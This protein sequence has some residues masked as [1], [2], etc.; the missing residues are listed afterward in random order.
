M[1]SIEFRPHIISAVAWCPL[2]SHMPLAPRR[3]RQ[4]KRRRPPTHP[5]PLPFLQAGISL[6]L[7]LSLFRRRPPPLSLYSMVSGKNL[8]RGTNAQ[9]RLQ[10]FFHYLLR[11]NSK[12]CPLL[13]SFCSIALVFLVR[14]G[15]LSL[16]HRVCGRR[17]RE[18]RK[19]K[20]T[21]KRGGRERRRSWER[22]KPAFSSGES[23]LGARGSGKRSLRPFSFAFTGGQWKNTE[24]VMLEQDSASCVCWPVHTHTRDIVKKSLRSLLFQNQ[25]KRRDLFLVHIDWCSC[26]YK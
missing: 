16:C 6:F 9:H 2:L 11:L 18:R 8:M 14:L 26:T 3:R 13:F 15:P 22:E 17:G 5:F 24:L 7:P 20:G 19:R 25:D 23:P 12:K 10:R 1:E 21:Q 4:K